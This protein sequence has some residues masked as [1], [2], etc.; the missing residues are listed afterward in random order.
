VGVI[1]QNTEKTWDCIL[2]AR[3]LETFF[4]SFGGLV[5]RSYRSVPY[6]KLISVVEIVR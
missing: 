4:M 5:I 2:K 3:I 1:L 6:N